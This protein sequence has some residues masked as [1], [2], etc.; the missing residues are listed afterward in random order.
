MQYSSQFSVIDTQALQ[1][2]RNNS[3][4][5]YLLEFDLRVVSFVNQLNKFNILVRVLLFFLVSLLI[6]SCDNDDPANIDALIPTP[7]ISLEIGNYWIYQTYLEDMDGVFQPKSSLDSMFVESSE[8][9]NG[10]EYF[11]IKNYSLGGP[12]NAIFR[13]RDSIGYLVNDSGEIEYSPKDDGSVLFENVIPYHDIA[14]I[15]VSYTLES[16]VNLD[17]PAGSFEA[18]KIV[19]NFDFSETDFECDNQ[20]S[21]YYVEDIG[22]VRED[23]FYASTCNVLYRELL[24]YNIQ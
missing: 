5:I 12:S 14:N 18:R 7:I 16:T 24:R 1:N 11:L 6:V 15:Y 8:M 21:S 17:T 20:N 3:T 4:R 10:N 13:V 22:R 2:Y 19:G 23:L 9:V